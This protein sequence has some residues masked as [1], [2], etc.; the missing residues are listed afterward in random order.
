MSKFLIWMNRESGIVP[1]ISGTHNVPLL[2]SVPRHCSARS[3]VH[4][5]GGQAYADEIVSSK[6]CLES[7]RNMCAERVAQTKGVSPPFGEGVTS[8]TPGGDGGQDLVD[9][10]PNVD[11]PEVMANACI[12]E[13]VN[14][15]VEEEWEVW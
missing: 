5:V 3:W 4:T 10:E 14:V 15:A 11:V 7:L 12:E 6:M 2:G 13:Q 9:V 8:P 1:A